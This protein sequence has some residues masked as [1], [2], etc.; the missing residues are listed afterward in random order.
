MQQSA[1]S[2]WGRAPLTG[3]KRRRCSAPAAAVAPLAP[4]LPTPPPLP[5]PHGA[6]DRA[7]GL[8]GRLDHTLGNLNALYAHPSLDLSLWGEGNLVRLVRAGRTRIHPDRR[9][10]G[11]TCG[12]IPLAGPATATTR[13]LKWDMDGLRMA[14]RGLI[15]SCNVITADVL[16][17][18]VDEDVVWTTELREAALT[19][20]LGVGPVGGG[21]PA[22]GGGPPPAA[23]P[24]GRRE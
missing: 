1:R 5:A 21:G 17:V 6:R 16:E 12:L 14:F 15:S 7:G 18:E 23:A 19:A 9:F 8:G 2:S 20:A 24:Q 13:G 4:P 22:G 10:E 11:P 3:R